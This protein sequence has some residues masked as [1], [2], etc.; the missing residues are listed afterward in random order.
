MKRF[1]LIALILGSALSMA[2][3]WTNHKGLTFSAHSWQIVQDSP[4][5]TT[6][7]SKGGV[8]FASV[9]DGMTITADQ[10]DFDAIPN[11]NK[12][13]TYLL[14]HAVA[15]KDVK[16]VKTVTSPQG[17]QT[18]EVTG[19][20]ADYLTGSRETV[21][22]ILGPTTIRNL[23]QGQQQSM[24]ATG[25]SGIAYLEPGV[26]VSS[27]NGLRR[28]TLEGPVRVVFHQAATK[29][30]SA[31]DIT[32]TSSQ[33]QLENVGQERRIT[34]IGSVHVMGP[35][36]SETTGVSRAL[37]VHDPDKGWHLDLLGDK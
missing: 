13:K 34:L 25:S 9:S 16:I 11:P 26:Q 14:S 28:A 6:I 31:S 22:K 15:T 5:L 10:L 35:N 29:K 4:K 3:L 30:E 37:M 19:P 24:I 27:G 7:K 21:V 12:P 17:R 32:A 1:S 20:K 33:L 2:E 23:D 36:G 8:S 18:T